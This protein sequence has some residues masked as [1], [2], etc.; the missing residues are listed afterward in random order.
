MDQRL[1]GTWP[2][3]K[4]GSTVLRQS[5]HSLLAMRGFA[6]WLRCRLFQH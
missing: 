5:Q 4:A 3:R 2:V 1:S 6:S